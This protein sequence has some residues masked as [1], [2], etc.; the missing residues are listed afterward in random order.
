M[1][2]N[3]KDVEFIDSTSVY[4]HYKIWIP[5]EIVS[6]L[7]A[8]SGGTSTVAGSAYAILVDA[9]YVASLGTPLTAGLAAC[10]AVELTWLEI[11]NDGCGVEVD[12][13]LVENYASPQL[14]LN[15]IPLHYISSQ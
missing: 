11:A 13:Y 10:I 1:P 7:V 9:G 14:F 4:D 3:R 6:D 15:D 8:L 2:C 12:V 5:D